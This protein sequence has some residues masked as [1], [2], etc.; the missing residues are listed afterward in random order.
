MENDFLPLYSDRLIINKTTEDDVDLLLKT[1][2]Q[3]ETQKFLGGVKNKTE[4][5]RR[6]FLRRK[7]SSLT[8]CLKDGTKIGFVGLKINDNVGTLSYMIDYDFVK[9]GYCTE[10]VNKIIEVGFKKLG[11]KKIDAETIDGNIGSIR[12]LEKVGLVLEGVRKGEAFVDTLNEYR[13]FLD[14][15]LLKENYK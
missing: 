4:E 2:K 12:V 1:D 15:G 5:E 8:V 13:D 9:H 10:A 3:E 11:L 14:Y 6:E 7:T